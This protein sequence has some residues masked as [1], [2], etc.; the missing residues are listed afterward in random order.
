MEKLKVNKDLEWALRDLLS[1][2]RDSYPYDYILK[3]QATNK[4]WMGDWYPLRKLS[5]S[6]MAKAIYVGYELELTP[7]EKVIEYYN[8]LHEMCEKEIIRETLDLLE[9]KIKGINK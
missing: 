2:N 9:L 8:G 7:E 5:V 6:E 1:R 3:I 4:E